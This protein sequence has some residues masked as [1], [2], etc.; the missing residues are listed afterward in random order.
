VR[1]T[2]EKPSDTDSGFIFARLARDEL[3][4]SE[5]QVLTPEVAILKLFSGITNPIIFV[6]DFA[7]S[8]NQFDTL[9]H[10]PYAIGAG[11]T[12]AFCDVAAQ[13]PSTCYYYC[14]LI[15][16]WLAQRR[17]SARCPQVHLSP[18]YFWEEEYSAFHPLSTLW[19]ERLRP[20]SVSF[21]QSISA[22]AGLP[23]LGGNPGDWR[24]FAKMG[25]ALAFEHG[26]PDA[27]LP[28]FTTAANGWKPLLRSE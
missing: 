25:L 15:C 20:N 12:Y 4:I 19:P 11:R 10:R 22:R 5:E 9:W 14:P 28:I 27:T 2:G 1:V 6:D 8:G 18:A 26:T 3:R 13:Y 7:G 21:L 16:A 24:G 23:D 17:I